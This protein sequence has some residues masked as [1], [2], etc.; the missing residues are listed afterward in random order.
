MKRK[1]FVK[2]VPSKEWWDEGQ[3]HRPVPCFPFQVAPHDYIGTATHLG[4]EESLQDT[5]RSHLSLNINTG[6]VL[7]RHRSATMKKVLDSGGRRRGMLEP[8][9]WM[10][11]RDYG[12]LR[13]QVSHI[14]MPTLSVMLSCLA[15]VGVSGRG[16]W[17]ATTASVP[18][19][20]ALLSYVE[21][22]SVKQ[23]PEAVLFLVLL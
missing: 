4:H 5:V 20:E 15:S 23:A 22:V 13:H 8:V 9:V 1:S 10:E 21:T 2:T 7:W 17:S 6:L 16:V 11:Q 18:I 14:H 3:A 19:L 12:Q